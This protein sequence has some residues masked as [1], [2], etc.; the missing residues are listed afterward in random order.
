[1]G[2]RARTLGLALAL[3][4]SLGAPPVARA[5]GVSQAEAAAGLRARYG[6]AF[7][8]VGGARDEA[9]KEAAVEKA[10]STLFFAIR[11]IARSRVRA[12]TR[13]APS[14]RF[15]FE[16]SM[17]RVKAENA[18]DAVAPESGASAPFTYEGEKLSLS[19]TL[20]AAGLTQTFTAEDGQRENV[21]TLSADG[22]SLVERVTIRS[23]KL[24]APLVY[25]LHY[26]PK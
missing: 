17:I 26:A 21:W 13:I 23:P 2:L 12:R 4:S 9:A 19:Q 18:P 10:T 25:T 5:D 8:W 20:T 7:Q 15:S 11:G 3:S 1:M 24:S 22:K 16:G 6:R 14:V